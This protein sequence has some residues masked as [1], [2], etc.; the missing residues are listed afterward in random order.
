M[1][2]AGAA[3]ATWT[4][5]VCDTGARVGA[6]LVGVDNSRGSEA[7]EGDVDGSGCNKAIV[8]DAP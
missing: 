3:I 8:E 7:G 1:L 2:G 6:L 5:A 4:C